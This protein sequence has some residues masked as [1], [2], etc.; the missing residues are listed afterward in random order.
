MVS[1][2]RIFNVF[3]TLKYHPIN[4]LVKNLKINII[5]DTKSTLSGAFNFT[6]FQLSF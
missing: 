4:C 5:I 6:L 3:N 2:I 1:F